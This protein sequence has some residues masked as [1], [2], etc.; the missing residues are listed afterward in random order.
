MSAQL[1]CLYAFLVQ[2]EFPLN[3]SVDTAIV[4]DRMDPI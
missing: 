4:L 2:R 3:R 1:S